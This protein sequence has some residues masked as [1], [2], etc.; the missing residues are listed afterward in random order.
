[1]EVVR[2]GWLEVHLEIGLMNGFNLGDEVKG[3]N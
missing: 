1:M 3:R 2:R